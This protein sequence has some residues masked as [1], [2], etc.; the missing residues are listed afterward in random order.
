MSSAESS[1]IQEEYERRA[2]AFPPDFYSF[3]KPANLLVRQSRERAVVRMLAR[4]NCLPLGQ[5]RILDV[6]CGDGQWLVD[7]ET[8]GAKRANLAGID[9]IP[10]RVRDA[11]TRLAA[12]ADDEGKVLS[13]AAD[14][15]EG[16]ASHLPWRD[17]AFD[18]VCQSMVFSSILDNNMQT[19]VA[20][21]MVRVLAPDGV[22]LWYDFFVNNPRNR[23]VRGV[24]KHEVGRLFPG[25]VPEVRRVTLLPPLARRVAPRSWLLAE[26]I[27]TMK[28]LN[29]HLLITLRRN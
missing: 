7:F 22:I 12:W 14:I 27:E 21:E 29:T 9:L 28:F 24:R 20:K 17:Q 11:R 19:V 16:D 2:R 18:I 1:R 13:E 10:S 5:R 23:N 15:R 25:F 26:L 6:G 8:W 4:S 3:T